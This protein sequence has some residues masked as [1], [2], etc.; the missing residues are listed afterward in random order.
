MDPPDGLTSFDD[1]SRCRG[2]YKLKVSTDI[3]SFELFLL[4]FYLFYLE[5]SFTNSFA[6]FFLLIGKKKRFSNKNQ[7]P[8]LLE[9]KIDLKFHCNDS[10]G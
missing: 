5:N 9:R 2:L 7:G 1:T 3:C 8:F 6:I 10:K 4:N